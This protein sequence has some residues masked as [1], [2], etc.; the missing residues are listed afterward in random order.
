MDFDKIQ[1]LSNKYLDSKKHFERAFKV[2]QPAYQPAREKEKKTGSSSSLS[3]EVFDLK[4]GIGPKKLQ[5]GKEICL[6]YN[7]VSGCKST[8]CRYEHACAFLNPPP[9]VELVNSSA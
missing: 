2:D 6:Y 8:V 1:K 5:D 3:N 9:L 7:T 4:K